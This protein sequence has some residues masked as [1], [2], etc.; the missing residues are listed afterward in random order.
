MTTNTKPRKPPAKTV[1]INVALPQAVHRKLRVK[2]L[3]QE[4][5][6]AE[7]VAAAVAA[8]TR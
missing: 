8:W 2:A 3:N 4:M 1:A 5:T 6:L 7:A